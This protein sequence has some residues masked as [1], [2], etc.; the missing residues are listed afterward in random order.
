[1]LV[2]ILVDIAI[3]V[4]VMLLRCVI[5]IKS[6]LAYMGIGRAIRVGEI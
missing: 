6:R 2:K 4:S 5:L 1:M 3:S